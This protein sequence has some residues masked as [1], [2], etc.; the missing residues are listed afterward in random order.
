MCG[1]F[2]K[3]RM[4]RLCVIG[5]LMGCFVKMRFGND[6]LSPWYPM[7][8]AIF[9]QMPLTNLVKKVSDLE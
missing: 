9:H 2:F 5:H 8:T 6:R 4:A 3:L 7:R 1:M